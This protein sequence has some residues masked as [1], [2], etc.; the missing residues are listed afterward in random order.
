ME[1][2]LLTAAQSAVG[3][4][5]GVIVGGVLGISLALQTTV[6]RMATPYVDAVSVV[7]PI[8]FGPM[9]VLLFGT[10]F[11][12]KAGFAGVAA[13][14]AMLAYAFAGASSIDPRWL[15]MV[16]GR[17]SK[18][19]RV[20]STIIFPASLGWIANGTRAALA[21][22]LIGA[23]VGQLISSSDGLGYRIQR[24][25][26]LFDINGVWVGIIGF[27]V[28]GVALSAL[29]QGAFSILRHYYRHRYSRR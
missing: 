3:L 10:G 14:L 21:A 11:Q 12:M 1:D 6:R 23:F 5:V 25:L 15:E 7:P 28:V 20:W 9:A 26:G 13:G 2:M 29:L 27:A 17:P 18:R 8:A 22:A 4:L 24:A 16:R 19:F